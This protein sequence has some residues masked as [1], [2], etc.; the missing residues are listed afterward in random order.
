M[1]FEIDLI[2]SIK[3]ISMAPYRL[4]PKEIEELW[5]QIDDLKFKGLI[6]STLAVRGRACVGGRRRAGMRCCRA[7]TLASYHAGRSTTISEGATTRP[8]SSG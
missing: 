1:E 4:A 3:P 5:L 6:C 7:G 8:T 2:P